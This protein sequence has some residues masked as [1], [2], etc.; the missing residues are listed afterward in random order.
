MRLEGA[1]NS[2]HRRWIPS[3]LELDH[4]VRGDCDTEM[5]FRE[6]SSGWESSRVSAFQVDWLI[7]VLTSTPSKHSITT[8]AEVYGRV[9]RHTLLSCREQSIE[10]RNAC[11]QP[12]QP[13]SSSPLSPKSISPLGSRRGAACGCFRAVFFFSPS[14]SSP[15]SS[16]SSPLASPHC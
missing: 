3:A 7:V 2:I 5:V 4:E 11:Y 16:S 9:V 15:P 10:V 6:R 13:L 1:A 8:A 14:R 12:A